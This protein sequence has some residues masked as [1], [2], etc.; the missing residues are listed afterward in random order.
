M[1]WVLDELGALIPK[2]S[3]KIWDSNTLS[4]TSKSGRYLK[5]MYESRR[6]QFA[7]LEFKNGAVQ[8]SNFAMRPKYTASVTSK[9]ITVI[10]QNTGLLTII[11]NGVAYSHSTIVGMYDLRVNMPIVVRWNKLFVYDLTYGYLPVQL[12]GV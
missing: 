10:P 8:V 11:V 9:G 7:N 1:L 12:G 2:K 4:L 5:S 6:Y 3:Y